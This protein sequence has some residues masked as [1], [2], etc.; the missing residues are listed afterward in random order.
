MLVSIGERTGHCRLSWVGTHEDKDIWRV[1]RLVLAQQGKLLECLRNEEFSPIV[2][3]SIAWDAI[4]Y[5]ASWG[6][7]ILNVCAALPRRKRLLLGRQ[8]SQGAILPRLCSR[9][10]RAR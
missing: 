4:R 2:H 3:A 7:M 9:S 6:A 10:A 1:G 8:S 5:L